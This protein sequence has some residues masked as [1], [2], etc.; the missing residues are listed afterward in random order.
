[1]HHGHKN[2]I[3]IRVLLTVF[4]LLLAT[5][6]LVALAVVF[7]AAPHLSSGTAVDA[8][9]WYLFSFVS[10]VMTVVLPCSLPLLFVVVPL[11]LG[12][13][14]ERALGMIL[15]FALGVVFVLSL[16]G[17]A[18]AYFGGW[19]L[20]T[21]H[22]GNSTVT[23][24]MYY[25]AGIF[26]YVLALGE[27]GLIR[28]R[29]PS[30]TGAAPKFIQKQKEHKKMF[31]LG[32]F[33]ANIG[34]GYPYPATPLLLINA[35]ASNSVL[36]GT[37][38]F[39]VHGLG[40]VIPLVLLTLLA[41]LSING[42]KHLLK[43]KEAID[44]ANGWVLLFSSGFILTLGLFTHTWFAG[45]SAGGHTL[46]QSFMGGS[47][48][49][50]SST[51]DLRGILGQPLSWGNWC[52]LALW[53]VPLW[54]HYM[55]ERAR[56]FG[57]ELLQIRH[58]E[59]SIDKLEVERRAIEVVLYLPD[60]AG[61]RHAREIRHK[62]DALEKERRIFEEAVR[63]GV[64]KELRG[65]VLDLSLHEALYL[66]RNWYITLTILLLTVFIVVL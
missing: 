17:A 1:M 13:G 2:N 26:A 20:N 45:A 8:V 28:M 37:L 21:F 59:R 4:A 6:I 14:P 62:I 39:L 47:F 48:V 42:L 38:L 43:K 40:R 53:L 52:L 35:G 10:G 51:A 55:R 32:M 5:I 49:P 12:R 64:H 34:V 29:I 22:I 15:T 54:W 36:Y 11:A 44:H 23:N 57:K 61:A 9:L 41:V 46:F 56:I 33:L 63:Y 19:V 16:Y 58:I 60:D 66:R 7:L 27:V 30:Y 24:W 25:F 65:D 3:S 18:V 31:L 50:Q